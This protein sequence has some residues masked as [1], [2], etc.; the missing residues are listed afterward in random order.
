MSLRDKLVER[1]VATLLGVQLVLLGIDA[2]VPAL[3]PLIPLAVPWAVLFLL[4]LK[5]VRAGRA[6]QTALVLTVTSV[7]ALVGVIVFTGGPQ[8]Y[9]A[10]F[11][12][13]AVMASASWFGRNALVAVLGVVYVGLVGSWLLAPEPLYRAS[14]AEVLMVYVCAVVLTSAFLGAITLDLRRTV[15]LAWARAAEAEAAA[16]AANAADEA[17]NRFLATV[18]HDLRTPLDTVLGYAELLLEEEE[19]PDRASDL[20]RIRSAGWQLLSLV[21]DVL[22]MSLVEQDQLRV[23]HEPVAIG[24]LIEQVVQTTGAQVTAGR[25]RI[26]L[27]LAPGLPTLHSDPARIRQILLNLVSNAAKYT[28]DGEIRIRVERVE[29]ALWLSVCDSGIGIPAEQLHRLFQPFVQLHE[30]PE[31]RPGIGLGLALS[32][33]L[34]AR[35][36]GRI[37]VESEAGRGSTFRLEVPL[38]GPVRT[39]M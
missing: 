13:L 11:L 22:D 4:A 2:C 20:G 35:L 6:R 19:D 39:E 18:S 29:D 34:A 8:S 33:G 28:T 17:R 10:A 12:P 21:D 5:A 30:G 25:N 15:D 26:V 32:Q 27:D 1:S 38:G 7:P 23:V 3:R 16:E 37:S 31:R 36:G 24:A 14:D 9:M